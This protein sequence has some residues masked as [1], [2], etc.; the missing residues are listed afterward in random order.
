MPRLTITSRATTAWNTL[1]DLFNRYDHDASALE[2]PVGMTN[3]S[4]ATWMRSHDGAKVDT[5]QVTADDSGF[6]IDMFHPAARKIDAGH[7]TFVRFDDSRR[8]YE[9]VK[10]VAS[11][12]RRI[13]ACAP[14]G[15]RIQV[16]LHTVA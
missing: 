14:F 10:V 12:E 1:I 6:P 4:Y 8:D 3:R 15:D 11:D 7:T 2:A 9:G 13:L 16:F 5:V